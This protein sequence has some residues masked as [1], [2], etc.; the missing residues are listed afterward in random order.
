MVPHPALQK[1]LLFESQLQLPRRQRGSLPHR[2]HSKTWPD[3]VRLMGYSFLSRKQI[4]S[5]TYNSSPW[6][7]HPVNWTGGVGPKAE[8]VTIAFT[9]S[10]S[11]LTQNLYAF[12]S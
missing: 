9:S 2:D 1:Q 4:S 11:P 6:E 3:V 12:R 5:C 8:A 10:P 7:W